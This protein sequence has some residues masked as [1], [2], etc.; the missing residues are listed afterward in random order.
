MHILHMRKLRH[1]E[2]KQ[3]SQDYIHRKLLEPLFEPGQYGYCS[4]PLPYNAHYHYYNAHYHNH[5]ILSPTI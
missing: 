1:G 4:L 3:F 5:C 2:V